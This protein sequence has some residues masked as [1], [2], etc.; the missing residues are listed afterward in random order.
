MTFHVAA[1]LR[2]S[3]R[4]SRVTFK[5]AAGAAPV[6]ERVIND[7]VTCEIIL[8]LSSSFR[9]AVLRHVSRRYHANHYAS[10]STIEYPCCNPRTTKWPKIFIF[11]FDQKQKS[12]FFLSFRSFFFVY[13]VS[14]NLKSKYF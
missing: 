12:P 3:T 4:H 11:Q 6:C 8:F 9:V 14:S 5:Y 7:Y 13:I 10:W 1:Y 2:F